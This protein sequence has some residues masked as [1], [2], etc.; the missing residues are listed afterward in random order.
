MKPK[1]EKLLTREAVAREALMY[2]RARLGSQ[3]EMVVIPLD[4]S[5]GSAAF[6]IYDEH[7]ADNLVQISVAL[8][9]G[10]QGCHRKLWEIRSAE[11]DWKRL[12]TD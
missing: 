10:E 4:E 9:A 7:N 1:T 5:F 8:T 6:T 11:G 2:V 3:A 12:L